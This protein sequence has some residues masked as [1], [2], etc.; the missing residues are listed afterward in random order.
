MGRSLTL[1]L[2]NLYRLNRLILYRQVFFAADSVFKFQHV[3][4]PRSERRWTSLPQDRPGPGCGIVQLADLRKLNVP[5]HIPALSDHRRA[6]TSAP[7]LL[8]DAHRR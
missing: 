7:Q 4:C 5:G 2:L 1:A 6:K 3:S 8:R